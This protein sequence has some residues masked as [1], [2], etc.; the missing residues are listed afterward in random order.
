MYT[1]HNPFAILIKEKTIQ[2]YAIVIIIDTFCEDVKVTTFKHE[3]DEADYDVW[4]IECKNAAYVLKKVSENELS[5]YNTFSASA[6]YGTPRFC[7]SVNYSGGSFM[8]IEY[9]G[10]HDLRKCTRP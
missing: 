7:K 8:L 3:E 2:S 5:V 4:K 10:G 6:E 9:I 1:Q